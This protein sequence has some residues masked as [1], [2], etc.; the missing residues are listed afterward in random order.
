MSPHEAPGPVRAT[1]AVHPSA[2]AALPFILIAVARAFVSTRASALLCF[3]ATL[4]RARSPLA[5]AARAA[6]GGLA[7]LL[8]PDRCAACDG[9]CPDGDPLC[10]GCAETVEADASIEPHERPRGGAGEVVACARYRGAIVRAVRR[11]KYG[12]RPDL[13]GP[14]GRMLGEAARGLVADVVVPVPL[15]PRKLRARGYNQAAL[16]A[17]AVAR[18]LAV[19]LD[20]RMLVR[21]RDTS[22]Q[23]Q[24]DRGE[25]LRNV[26]GVFRAR[27]PGNVRGRR[28]VLVDDVCTTG[29]TLRACRDALLAAGAAVVTPLVLARAERAG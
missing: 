17:G 26:D 3:F 11:F 28:V 16:L 2:H 6:A 21:T 5:T 13:A 15:H 25:R 12:E 18:L 29:S 24:L 7:R 1:G 4:V 23:A 19:P 27:A 20:A 14:L 22:A 9:P 8:A 10:V